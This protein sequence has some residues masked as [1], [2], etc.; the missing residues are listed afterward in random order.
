MS[1]REILS[2]LYFKLEGT[3]KP[4]TCAG[5]LSY[6]KCINYTIGINQFTMSDKARQ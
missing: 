5:G 1:M 2:I 3:R 6:G 4:H